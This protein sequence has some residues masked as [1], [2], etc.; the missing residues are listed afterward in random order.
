MRIG[1]MLRQ[2]RPTRGRGAR[3]IRVR[4]SRAFAQPDEHEYV[5]YFNNP[6]L[7]ALMRECRGREVSIPGKSVLWW[8]Q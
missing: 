7:L 6:A 5:L 8:D 2:L 3:Y 1:I 4:S